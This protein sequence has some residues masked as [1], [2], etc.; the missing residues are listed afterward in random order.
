[1]PADNITHTAQWTPITY[2]ITYDLDGGSVVTA[3]PTTYNIETETFT[4]INPTLNDTSRPGYNFVGWT[5]S[6]G[7]APETTITIAQGSMGDKSYTANWSEY[8]YA[9]TIN[10]NGGAFDPWVT[11]P[12]GYNESNEDVKIYDKPS[13]DGYSFNGWKVTDTDYPADDITIPAGSTGNRSYKATWITRNYWISYNL[14]GGTNAAGNPD[15]YNIETATFTINPPTREGYT[16]VGWTGWIYDTP[17]TTI[18]VPT[19]T[20][21]NMTLTAVWSK[22][23]SFVWSEGSGTENDPYIIS[24]PT[25]LDQLATIVN[26]GEPFYGYYFKLDRDITYTGG[27]ATESNYTAIG[28]AEGTSGIEWDINF[29][30]GTFDGDGHTISDIRIYRDGTGDDAH[31]QGLFGCISGATI[32]NVTL[33]DAVITGYKFVGSIAGLYEGGTIEN[34]HVTNSVTINTE[35]EGSDYHGGIA[36]GPCATGTGVTVSHCTSAAQLSIDANV[37]A[38]TC[39]YYGGIAG[40][41]IGN[42]NNNLVIGAT[43]PAVGQYYG[44]IGSITGKALYVEGALEM[45]DFNVVISNNFYANCTVGGVPNATDVGFG[46][47]YENWDENIEYIKDSG[48]RTTDWTPNNGAVSAVSLANN[49]DNSTQITALNG[50]TTPVILSDRTLYKDGYW[51]TLVL[52]FAISDFTG[53]PLE[54][55]T[56]K[57]LRTTSNLDNNG[58]LTLNF[59]DALTAI[60][61]GKPYIVKWS[62][63][64]GYDANPSNYD[65]VNPVFTGVTIDNTNRDVNFTGGSFMG[66]YAPLEITE[67]NRSKVLLLSGNNKLGYAKTDRTIANGKALGTC[68]AYFYFSDSQTAR[69]FVMN[70]EEEGTPT[71]VGRTEITESTEM[72]DA[73]YDL[74]G[75]R[76]EK[77]KKGLYIHRGKKV[78]VH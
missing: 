13:R 58:T 50:Q 21:V 64:A 33:T 37:D 26:A 27:S 20:M 10:L 40:E 25:D 67:A 69:S 22:D 76:I 2:N 32:K 38:S 14:N 71:G 41:A 9:L 59:S 1:M 19:G 42:I 34:C 11:V 39:N 61:A 43:V 56:V 55:A 15:K 23:F 52:P 57:E 54:D 72:A 63:D 35:Q 16:F 24:S 31:C 6:N 36:G 77:P 7:I 66:T 17:Q 73:I 5:G 29:F 28:K 65:L 49:A 8:Q 18:T 70:F 74:Q 12:T 60:E 45:V 4:L 62:K 68:R 51:N 78:L 53:T 44:A 46:Y 75:R 47:E 30:K 3:N 48:V